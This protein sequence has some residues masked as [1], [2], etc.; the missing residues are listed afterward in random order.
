MDLTTPPKGVQD[1]LTVVTVILGVVLLVLGAGYAVF[2]AVIRSLTAD[3]SDPGTFPIWIG[4][5]VAIVGIV[6]IRAGLKS[7]R[8]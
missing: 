7:P 3:V 2:G 6:L 4:S 8:K 5:F 1:W